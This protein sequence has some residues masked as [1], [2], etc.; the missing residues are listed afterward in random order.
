MVLNEVFVVVAIVK[1]EAECIL[2][3]RFS[4]RSKRVKTK[5]ERWLMSL[6]REGGLCVEGGSSEKQRGSGRLKWYWP[7]YSGRQKFKQRSGRLIGEQ[8]GW[9]KMSLWLSREG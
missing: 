4:C 6:K 9:W 5:V 7:C 2:N 3:I 8:K 1:T